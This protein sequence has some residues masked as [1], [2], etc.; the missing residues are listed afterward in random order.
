MKTVFWIDT[1]IPSRINAKN[2]IQKYGWSYDEK[3]KAILKLLMY[4]EEEGIEEHY[5]LVTVKTVDQ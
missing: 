4:N 1:Y 2:G 5:K 3:T